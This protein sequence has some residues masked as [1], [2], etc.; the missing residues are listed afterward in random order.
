MSGAAS[1]DCEQLSWLRVGANQVPA[2]LRAEMLKSFENALA[3]KR[4]TFAVVDMQ[5]L[6][7]PNNILQALRARGYTV[8]GP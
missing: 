3:T 7:G 6:V 2:S 4:L 1:A 5:D 8:N